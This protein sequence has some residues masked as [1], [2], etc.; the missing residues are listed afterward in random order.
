M[1]LYLPGRVG[2]RAGGERENKFF[3]MQGCD[4]KLDFQR[5]KKS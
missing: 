3:F 5:G 4:D 1:G 2:G